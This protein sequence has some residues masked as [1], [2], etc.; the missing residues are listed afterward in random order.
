[1][2]D[3]PL[4]KCSLNSKMS[5]LSANCAVCKTT[6]QLLRCQAC[7]VMLYCCREHQIVD[8]KS[9]KRECNA[10]KKSRE[11]FENEE[12]KLRTAPSDFM[13]PANVFQE[14]VGHFWGI[15]GTRPYMR[16]RYA[17]VDNLVKIKTCDAVKTAFD[18]I[19]DMLRLCRSD[20]MGLRDIV[21]AIFIRLEKDQEC[22]DFLKW[23]AT[24]G[25]RGDYDWGDMDLPFLDVKDADVFEAVSEFIGEYS[26]LSHAVPLMLIKMRLLRIVK[27]LKNT[28]FLYD[29]LPPELIDS[30]SKDIG[31][32]ILA[33]RKDILMSKDQE[34]LIKK[35][36][37]QV[38]ELFTFVK[39]S[40]K[41]FWPGLLDPAAYLAA[42]PT[43][44]SCGSEEHSQLTLQY[45]YDAFAETPGACDMIREFVQKYGRD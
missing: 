41:Y 35:L 27:S 31:G 22:Y 38:H 5:V 34:A 10:V 24:T 17:F 19:M 14:G 21:P 15:Y 18:H 3:P 9:H 11:D 26:D 16:A 2:D 33:K 1:M 29:R 6:I 39:K 32:K 23:Y 28:D 45:N 8:R 20:N 7:M 37:E 12:R 43:E 25:S 30:I 13:M 44:Y 4:L 40:N 36:E 42:K